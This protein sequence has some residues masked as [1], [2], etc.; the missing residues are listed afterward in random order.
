MLVVMKYMTT[1][2]SP[3]GKGVFL[4]LPVFDVLALPS[5]LFL[6]TLLLLGLQA[7]L[8]ALLELLRDS[9]FLLLVFDDGQAALVRVV[10]DPLHLFQCVLDV[11]QLTPCAL[12]GD[13]QFVGGVYSVFLLVPQGGDDLVV[14]PGCCRFELESHVDLGVDFIDVLTAGARGTGELDG[15]VV[16]CQGS[17]LGRRFVR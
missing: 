10:Y 8:I 17:W 6:V 3:R 14:H 11:A 12:A 4:R 16:P 15:D 13:D 5:A 1:M 7:L 9:L 2:R